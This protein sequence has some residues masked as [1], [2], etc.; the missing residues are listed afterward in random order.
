FVNVQTSLSPSTRLKS[1]ERLSLAGVAVP[2]P[3]GLVTTQLAPVALQRAFGSVSLIVRVGGL[4]AALSIS[5][6]P[7]KPVGDPPKVLRVKVGPTLLVVVKPSLIVKVKSWL[8]AVSTPSALMVCFRTK[9]SDGKRTAS[10]VSA[11][12]WEPQ[13]LKLSVGSGLDIPTM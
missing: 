13:Q 2:P 10:V 3:T 12:S 1:I 7:L 9:I 4:N 6:Y 8:Y 5:S 11:R